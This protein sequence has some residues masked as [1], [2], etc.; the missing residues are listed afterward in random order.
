[1]YSRPVMSSHVRGATFDSSEG[2]NDALAT[3]HDISR[4]LINKLFENIVHRPRAIK[5]GDKH[6]DVPRRVC[7]E[8]L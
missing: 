1:M 2:D 6:H 7:K 3:V 5:Q 4:G 8:L